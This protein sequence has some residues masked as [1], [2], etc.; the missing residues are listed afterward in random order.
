MTSEYRAMIKNADGYPDPQ[1]GQNTAISMAWE[2]KFSQA[3]ILHDKQDQPAI[4]STK[5]AG[6]NSYVAGE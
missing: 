5:G 1:T 3:F 6:A 2:V 4:T